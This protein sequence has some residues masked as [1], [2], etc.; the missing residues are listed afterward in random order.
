MFMFSIHFQKNL[1]YFLQNFLTVCEMNDTTAPVKLSEVPT[2]LSALEIEVI[3]LFRNAAVVLGLPRSVGEI[4]GL[5]YAAP[6]PLS[7]DDVIGKLK[8]SPGSA[9]QGLK[10]LRSFGAVK[11]QY[12][13]GER[14]D[15]F[16]VETELRTVLTGYLK[17]KVYPHLRSGGDRLVRMRELARVSSDGEREIGESR[18][19]KLERWHQI[20]QSTLPLVEKVAGA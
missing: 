17:E 3:D 16:V 2:T 6:D 12:V 7:M 4:Y 14:R 8:I 20:I 1:H 11:A 5:L 15:H 13:P 9:S 18:I 10:L 19:E